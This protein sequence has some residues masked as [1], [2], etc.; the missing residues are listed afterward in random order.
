MKRTVIAGIVLVIAGMSSWFALSP[1]DWQNWLGFSRAAYF[2]LGTNYAFF[3]GPG[4]FLVTTLGLSTIVAGLWHHLNCRAT[5]C[6]RVGTHPDSRGVKW[7]WRHHP[8]HQGQKPT[9]EMLHRLHFEH[10]ERMKPS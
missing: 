8:D 9:T 1:V 5:G 6:G 10:L 4:P 7:C 2:T 3:S